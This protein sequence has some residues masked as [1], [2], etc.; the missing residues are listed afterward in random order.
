MG[1]L[2]R[3]LGRIDDEQEGDSLFV[4]TCICPCRGLY[5]LCRGGFTLSGNVQGGQDDLRHDSISTGSADGC[6]NDGCILR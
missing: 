1:Q 6:Y 3:M 2:D 4:S 5:Q